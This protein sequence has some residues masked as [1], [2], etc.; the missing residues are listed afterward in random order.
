MKVKPHYIMNIYKTCHFLLFPSVGGFLTLFVFI[1]H[2]L[3]NSAI[4]S[5]SF[6]L[7]LLVIFLKVCTYGTYLAEWN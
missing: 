5:T 3:L 1:L 6:Y 2:T 7:V 4:S